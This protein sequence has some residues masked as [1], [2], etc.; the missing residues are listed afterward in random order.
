MDNEY[1]L[2]L[3][4]IKLI[5]GVKYVHTVKKNS[6]LMHCEMPTEYVEV[7]DVCLCLVSVFLVYLYCEC[8]NIY[9]GKLFHQIW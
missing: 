4:Q 9:T 5:T 6:N 3:K 7:F 2:W 1:N 8:V